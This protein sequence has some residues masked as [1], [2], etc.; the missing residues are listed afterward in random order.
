MLAV[1]E[2]PALKRAL[3]LDPKLIVIAADPPLSLPAELG[4][5]AAEAALELTEDNVGENF[6]VHHRLH[7]AA[8]FHTRHGP[9][10]VRSGR[11]LRRGADCQQGKSGGKGGDPE[12]AHGTRTSRNMPISMW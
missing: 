12:S 2:H 6:L 5:A 10:L 1:V 3:R 8:G 4:I 11:C 9:G 7:G